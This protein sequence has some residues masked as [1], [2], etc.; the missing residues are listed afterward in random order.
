VKK[1]ILQFDAMETSNS[2]EAP[3]ETIPLPD[4]ES[5]DLVQKNKR[6]KKEPVDVGPVRRSVRIAKNLGGYKDQASADAV[7]FIPVSEGTEAVFEQSADLLI[8][9]LAPHFEAVAYDADAP[10]PP[11]LPLETVKAIGTGLCQMPCEAVS[12][13]VLLDGSH[14]NV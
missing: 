9:N 14:D 1:F 12:D 7:G 11:H 6:K 10:P 8:T 3:S 4:E 2:V 13:E 5:V